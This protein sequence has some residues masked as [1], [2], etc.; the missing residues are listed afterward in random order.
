MPVDIQPD[1]VVLRHPAGASTTVLLYGAT[2]ISWIAPSHSGLASTSGLTERLDTPGGVPATASHDAAGIAPLGAAAQF[3]SSD[4]APPSERLFVSS[5]ASLDGTKPVRGGIPICWPIFGPP[6]RDEYKGLK[7]HGFARSSVWSY[8]ETVLDAAEGVSARFVL[9]NSAETEKVFP[10]PFKLVY[11]VTL[12]EH[13]LTTS[14]RV[15][16][17][18]AQPL[19]FQALLHNYF[20]GDAAVAQVQPLK[21]IG[22]VDKVRDGARDTE[23]RDTVDVRQYTDRVYETAGGAYTL[24]FPPSTHLSIKT[25]NLPDVTVWN[26]QETGSGMADMEP[27]GW[28]RYVCV[29]PGYVARFV[30]LPG[31]G[32]WWGQQVLTVL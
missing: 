10:Q 18:G 11:T 12:A 15:Y 23:Q 3:K 16:N 20:R 22:Y 7:Q 32:E 29:E 9:Q 30:S 27:G 1:R 21:G 6:S 5:L 17:T 25:H 14:L 31:G 13:Q 2:V 24:S 4:A 28:E 8:G 19:T 26:P